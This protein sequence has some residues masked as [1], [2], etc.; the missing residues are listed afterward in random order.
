MCAPLVCFYR[1]GASLSLRL[2]QNGHAKHDKLR[3]VGIKRSRWHHIHTLTHAIIYFNAS[4][5]D[6][7]FPIL[8][9]F[10]VL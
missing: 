7:H 4:C 5:A 3:N 2:A 9:G 1:R 8:N 10:N 6:S